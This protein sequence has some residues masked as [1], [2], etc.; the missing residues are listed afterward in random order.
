MRRLRTRLQN[1]GRVFYL[2]LLVHGSACSNTTSSSPSD[3]DT[4][5]TPD[6]QRPPDDVDTQ[7]MTDAVSPDAQEDTQIL[8]DADA[9]DT[10]SDQDSD[11]TQD[12]APP[13]GALDQDTPDLGDGEITDDIASPLDDTAAPPDSLELDTNEPDTTLPPIRFDFLLPLMLDLLDEPE[14]L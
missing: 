11:E 12:G 6:T 8:A 1:L 10:T 3:P 7:V 9:S 2:G 14:T 4:V 5:E 13:D